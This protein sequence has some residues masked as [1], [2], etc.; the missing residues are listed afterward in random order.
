MDRQPPPEQEGDIRQHDIEELARIMAC[1]V[2]PAVNTDRCTKQLWEDLQSNH[3]AGGDI[4]GMQ[5]RAL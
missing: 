4:P 3:P 2:Q 1:V 5:L